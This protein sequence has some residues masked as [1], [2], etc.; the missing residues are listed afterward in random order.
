MS[1]AVS[2]YLLPFI[3]AF[4]F[5]LIIIMPVMPFLILPIPKESVG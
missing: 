5:I 3:R 1:D 2:A 4:F